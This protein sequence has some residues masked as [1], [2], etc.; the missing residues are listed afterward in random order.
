MRPARGTRIARGCRPRTRD[1]SRRPIVDVDRSREP[2]TAIVDDRIVINSNADRGAPDGTDGDANA[3][4][5]DGRH[6]WTHADGRNDAGACDEDATRM[7]ARIGG[8][9]RA[10]GW[11]DGSRVRVRGVG[12]GGDARAMGEGVWVY[13]VSS[14]RGVCAY[15]RVCMVR[16][17]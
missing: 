2:V 1:V 15:M 4:R 3:G 8:R 13:A 5:V 16:Y 17:W 7:R 9:G 12:V 11:A 10:D 6:S 14:M